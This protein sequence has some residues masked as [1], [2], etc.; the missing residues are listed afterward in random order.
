MI[1][2][3]VGLQRECIII[4]VKCVM[5]QKVCPA[6]KILCHIQEISHDAK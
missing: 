2:K 5:S 6:M 4:H 1:I 3:C